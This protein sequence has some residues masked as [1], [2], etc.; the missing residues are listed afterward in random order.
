MGPMEG[1]SGSRATDDMGQILSHSFSTFSIHG[2]QERS[3][4]PGVEL[5]AFKQSGTP[6]T[7]RRWEGKERMEGGGGIP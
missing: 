4:K 5:A 7:R 2:C 1:M 6:A 3:G